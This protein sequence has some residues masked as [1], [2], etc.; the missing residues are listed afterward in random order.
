MIAPS[1]PSTTAPTAAPVP[2]PI[3]RIPTTV[4]NLL[5]VNI[6]PPVT[7]SANANHPSI[8][9]SRSFSEIGV[10]RQLL[11]HKIG[12]IGARYFVLEILLGYR[13][14]VSICAHA[15]AVGRTIVQSSRLCLI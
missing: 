8:R 15:L 10:F 1:S 7:P 2:A 4:N 12:D 14:T 6:T 3:P 9:D 11:Q 13:N 5:A